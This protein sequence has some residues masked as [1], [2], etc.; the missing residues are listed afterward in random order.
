MKD[1]LISE[2]AQ[3]TNDTRVKQIQKKKLEDERKYLREEVIGR[4]Q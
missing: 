1:K 3:I 2:I 4:L